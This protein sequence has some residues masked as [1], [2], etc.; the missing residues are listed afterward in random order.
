MTGRPGRG[1]EQ[2]ITCSAGHRFTTTARPGTHGVHCKHRFPDGTK[3]ARKGNVPTVPQ[4]AAPV[5]PVAPASGPAGGQT[6]P[7]AARAVPVTDGGDSRELPPASW[8]DALGPVAPGEDPCGDNCGCGGPPIRYT[9]DHTGTVCPAPV[10]GPQCWQPSSAAARRAKDHEAMLEQAARRER[11]PTERMPQQ[12]L[13]AQGREAQRRQDVLRMIVGAVLA[14]RHVTEDT[15]SDFRWFRG[16][17]GSPD[18][19][20]LPGERLDQLEAEMMACRVQRK[21]WLRRDLAATDYDGLD[22]DEDAYPD[23]IAGNVLRGDE[24]QA[25]R[26]ATPPPPLAIEQAPVPASNVLCEDCVARGEHRLAV[27]RQ[28]SP[29]MPHIPERNVCADDF[30]RYA[31]IVKATTFGDLLIIQRYGTAA[32]LRSIVQSKPALA[33]EPGTMTGKS[34]AWPARS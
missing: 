9:G 7:A 13:D 19:P 33:L 10:C 22:E 20:P 28:Q 30:R 17:L 24:D 1:L 34:A 21:G 8:R 18:S 15:R 27:A 12:A 5:A 29:N 32:G 11:K 25:P 14:D 3:C 16:Q 26:L 4:S 23:A 31:E 6:F 2:E